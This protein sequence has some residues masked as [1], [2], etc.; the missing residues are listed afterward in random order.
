MV[1]HFLF[2]HHP[3]RVAMGQVLSSKSLKSLV[4]VSGQGYHAGFLR[5]PVINSDD[6]R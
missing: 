5:C 4:D 6:E 3:E 2:T 1:G